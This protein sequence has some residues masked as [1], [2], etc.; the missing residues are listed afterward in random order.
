MTIYSNGCLCDY[1]KFMFV[2]F[3]SNSPLF[4]FHSCFSLFSLFGWFFFC[5]FLL[6]SSVD[7]VNIYQ[8]LKGEYREDGD[9]LSVVSSDKKIRIF[10]VGFIMSPPLCALTDS[11]RQYPVL[12]TAQSWQLHTDNMGIFCFDSCRIFR[13]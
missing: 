4:W 5:Y 8:L 9:R 11:G 1:R 3:F 13:T 10:Q 7:L 6:F 12:S 2:F